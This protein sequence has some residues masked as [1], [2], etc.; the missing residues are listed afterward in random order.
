MGPEKQIS[1]SGTNQFTLSL[2]PPSAQKPSLFNLVVYTHEPRRAAYYEDIVRMVTSQFPSRVIFIRVEEQAKTP[3]LKI[4]IPPNETESLQNDQILIDVAGEDINRVGSII[5]PN[6]IP[7]LPLYLL[8]SQDPSKEK[9]ILPYLQK[10]ATKLIMDSQCCADI[11][12]SSRSILSYAKSAQKEITDMDWASIR[13]WRE[14]VAESLNSQERIDKLNSCKEIRILY[15]NRSSDITL[16]PETQA[17][18]LQA[19]L[20]S[21][22]NWKFIK[23]E[24]MNS[25]FVLTYQSLS[26]Q[27]QIK[28]EGE[29]R[30]QLPPEEILLFEATNEENFLCSLTR[31]TSDQVLVHFNTID[32][33]ELPYTLHYTNILSGR[34]FMKEI[35]YKKTSSQYFNMLELISNMKGS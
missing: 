3:Y 5:L 7:D 18:Y 2:P 11:Q 23:S 22:M 20:A 24:K 10:Y 6:L 35:F 13:S 4:N 16:H 19:W 26:N 28:L 8:W 31:T 27:V 29:D 25:H 15:N 32:R 17:F 30:H 1:N 12:S 21:Q 14:I 34:N 33:C 9:N